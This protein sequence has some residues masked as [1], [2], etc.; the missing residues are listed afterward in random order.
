MMPSKS[1]VTSL[2][3]PSSALADMANAPEHAVRIVRR[4]WDRGLGSRL[5]GEDALA[6]VWAAKGR[7]CSDYSLSCIDSRLPAPP[8]SDAAISAVQ[9]PAGPP[10]ACFR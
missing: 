1:T 9:R 5:Q 2:R 4:K 3:S 6:V 8:G 7:A 10:E